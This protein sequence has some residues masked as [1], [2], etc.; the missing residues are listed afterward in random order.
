M[1]IKLIATTLIVAAVSLFSLDATAGYMQAAAPVPAAAAAQAPLVVKVDGTLPADLQLEPGQQVIFV[2]LRH[3]VGTS[4][5]VNAIQL[6]RMAPDLFDKLNT[7]Q[8]ADPDYYVVGAYEVKRAGKGAFD[9]THTV[10]APGAKP[11]TQRIAVTV[12]ASRTLV[13]NVDQKLPSRIEL[14]QGQKVLFVR[15]KHFV[16][17][18]V[19]VIDMGG[20]V[21]DATGAVPADSYLVEGYEAVKS[22]SGRIEVRH[23][24]TYPGARW[25]TQSI[26]LVVK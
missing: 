6:D 23:R 13:I 21:N 26:K 2:R 1:N 5:D 25:S 14:K 8:V 24:G 15:S 12:A 17:S 11:R 4:V 10:V 7:A 16:G 22:G 20:L 3:L 19:K 18:S 9:V